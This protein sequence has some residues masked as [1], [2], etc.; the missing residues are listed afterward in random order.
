MIED[1][2]KGI[3]FGLAIT[4]RCNMQCSMCNRFID[5][6]PWQ[7][8][9]DLTVADVKEAGEMVIASSLKVN[10]VRVTGGEPTLHPQ[11]KEICDS[12]RDDWKV[13]KYTHILTNGTTI[14]KRPRD[15]WARYKDGDETTVKIHHPFSISPTDLGMSGPFGTELPCEQQTGCGRLFDAF[16]F[17][18]CV[19]SGSLGRLLRIDPYSKTPVMMGDKRI[20]KH[21]IFSLPRK[22]RWRIWGRWRA[23]QQEA[24]T[25]TYQDAE[26]VFKLLPFRFKRWKER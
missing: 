7:Q 17:S 20:C 16:G 25:K 1:L 5:K 18:F 10:K 4:Y 3:R 15:I 26:D 9:S 12:I 13:A 2:S 22:I 8:P 11:L 6:F 24:V 14:N 23:G 19:I 21:C